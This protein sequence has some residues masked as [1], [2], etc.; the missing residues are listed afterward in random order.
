MT[1]PTF[2]DAIRVRHE[3]E[4]ADPLFAAL[5]ARARDFYAAEG[6]T[7][8]DDITVTSGDRELIL[9]EG[10]AYVLAWVWVDIPTDETDAPEEYEAAADRLIAAH[11]AELAKEAAWAPCEATR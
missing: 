7:E 3:A 2:A 9:K 1:K 6:E 8:I 4:N 5:K 10:G 11:Q